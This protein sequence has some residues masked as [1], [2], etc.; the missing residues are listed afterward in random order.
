MEHR[1][2]LRA[3][4]AANRRD[5]LA[6]EGK[7]LVFTNGCF[8]LLH[9]GHVRYLNEAAALGDF[10]LI[11]LNSDRSV[12]S[13][14]GPSR[15]IHGESDR[16]ETL[17]AL[18]SVD[19]VCVFDDARATALIRTIRPHLYVKGGDYQID[20]LD[21]EERAA[22]EEVGAE[23]RI[24]PLAPAR[25]TSL[26]LQKITAAETPAP[27]RPIRL[28]V[29]GSGTGSNFQAILESID[30]GTL[31]AEVRLALSDVAN[32]GILSL[33]Q[34][35]QIPSAHIALGGKPKGLAR[36]AQEEIRDRLLDADVDLVILAGF[37]RVIKSP[38]IEAFRGRILNIHPSLLPRH[39]GLE[40][41]RQALEA[42]DLETGAT[43]HQVTEEIDAGEIIAQKVVAI[44]EDDT[45]ESL[46]QRIHRVEHEIFPIAIA[47]VGSA[48]IEKE[49][50]ARD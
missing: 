45:P 47:N 43:V 20:S 11:G 24:L 27:H 19:G 40:A 4:E 50:D 15:P 39:K 30:R 33:A 29:L 41:W 28:A 25:S 9:V 12:T 23:I 10:V 31:H 26:T 37:M 8:D 5:E 49:Q 16:A 14:K 17:L 42:G 36:S 34:S 3:D 46:H 22:L 21:P 44:R 32:S 13:L 35:R 48:L 6:R 18:R 7:Q 2:I 38:I 1:G